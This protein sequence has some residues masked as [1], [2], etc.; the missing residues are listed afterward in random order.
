M[1]KILSV[2]AIMLLLVAAIIIVRGLTFSSAQIKADPISIDYDPTKAIA[3]LAAAIRIKTISY[4]D[5]DMI[6][7]SNEKISAEAY[8]KMI[9]FYMQLIK[10]LS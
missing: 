6:H 1:K 2:A 3:N 10:N 5:R 7:G 8:K 4:D 9:I